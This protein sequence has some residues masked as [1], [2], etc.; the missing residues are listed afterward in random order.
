MQK[1]GALAMERIEGIVR[2]GLGDLEKNPGQLQHLAGLLIDHKL[3]GLSRQVKRLPDVIES[4]MTWPKEV[5]DTLTR[6][7]HA[8]LALSNAS[9]LTESEKIDLFIF[10][11]ATIR[12]DM[13]LKDREDI[14]FQIC[15][16][17]G[18]LE[19]EE[20]RLTVRKTFYMD[21]E[22]LLATNIEFLFGRNRTRPL[23]SGIF[24]DIKAIFYPGSVP[25]RVLINGARKSSHSF[26][27]S[28]TGL[29]DLEHMAADI[30]NKLS[31]NP[32]LLSHPYWLQ[33]MTLQRK[34]EDILVVDK[35]GHA[36]SVDISDIWYRRLELAA[37]ESELHLLVEWQPGRLQVIS[38]YCYETL[39][40]VA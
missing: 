28:P 24:Y 31:I 30:R 9:K 16:Q 10:C 33:D 36:L 11:G 15:Y 2:S 13:L 34:G 27:L 14:P 35:P 12:K 7:H 19:T 29:N 6:A 37:R 26:P 23:S 8:L 21:R 4:D 17:L 25:N 38:A 1:G 40:S 32:W 22:G 5:L 18:V 20:D 39:F 3:N